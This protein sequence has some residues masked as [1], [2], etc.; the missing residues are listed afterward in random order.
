MKNI[1]ASYHVTFSNDVS[2]AGFIQNG[3]STRVHIVTINAGS[4]QGQSYCKIIRHSK[5]GAPILHQFVSTLSF[6]KIY[7]LPST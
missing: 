7:R 6:V 3:C 1:E 2:Q 4:V 5:F